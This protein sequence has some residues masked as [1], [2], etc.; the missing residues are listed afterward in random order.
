MI[1]AQDIHNVTFEKTLRG[2]RMDEVDEFLGK[3]AEQI[4]TLTKEKA[5]LEKKMYILAEKVDQYRK[6]EETL[7]TALLNA[8]RLGETVVYEA[9]QKAETILYD[10]NS[11]ASQAKEEA[12][13]QVALEERAL[14]E[15]KRQVAQFKN[16]ILNLYK[17]HIESLSA[18]PGAEDHPA[19][20]EDPQPVAAVQPDEPVE[21]DSFDLPAAPESMEEPQSAAPQEQPAETEFKVEKPVKEPQDARSAKRKVMEANDDLFDQYQGIH[22]DD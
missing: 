3:V 11:K 21:L 1:T 8:Q 10:A 4:D 12:A 18:I 15:M 22:F 20:K 7:K 16:D 6:D 14:A 19:P 9:K 17:Q 13:E 5:D 2:Y